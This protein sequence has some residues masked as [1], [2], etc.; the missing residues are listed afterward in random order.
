MQEV[1]FRTTKYA[2]PPTVI[3]VSMGWE[4]FSDSP[5]FSG[6]LGLVVDLG[7]Q[8][9]IRALYWLS[10]PDLLVLVETSFP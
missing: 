6:L 2:F 7:P 9:G 1:R 4:Q 5:L 3:Q 8:Y 10:A